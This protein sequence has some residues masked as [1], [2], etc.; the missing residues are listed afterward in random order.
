ML[1][2]LLQP[3]TRGNRHILNSTVTILFSAIYVLVI[4]T[5]ANGQTV[6]QKASPPGTPA[7]VEE[8]I[9]LAEV[10]S[11]IADLALQDD[12]LPYDQQP[13]YWLSVRLEKITPQLIAGLDDENPKIAERCL[14]LLRN[15]P[16]SK[17]LID[18]LIAKAN[19]D[20]RSLRYGVLFQLEK[21]VADPRVIHVLDQASRD[22]KNA[23]KPLHRARWA[24]LA[25]H[26]DRAMEIVKR[27]LADPKRDFCD[28]LDAVR[29]LGKI[30]DENSVK[31]LESVAADK[32]DN[33]AIE[34]YLTLAKIDPVKHGLT[35]DQQFLLEITRSGKTSESAFRER[36]SELG[37]LNVKE[38]RPLVMHMLRDKR[39]EALFILAAWKDQE[40]LPQIRKL[41][42]EENSPYQQQVCV[43]TYLSIDN[44]REAQ[45]TVL[46]FLVKKSDRSNEPILRGIGA[47]AMPADIK[48]SML[49]AAKPK[50]KSI[51]STILGALSIAKYEGYDIQDMLAPLMDE[52]TDLYNLGLYCEFAVADKEKRFAGQVRHAM[53]LLSSQPKKTPQTESDLSEYSAAGHLILKAVAA[54]ELKDLLADVKD[55][56]DSEDASIR[57]SALAAA[58]ILGDAGALEKLYARLNDKDLE[59]RKQASR[60]IQ[61]TK[62]IDDKARDVR[63]KTIIAC[64]GRPSEDYAMRLLTACG[65]DKAIEALKPILDDPNLQRSIH[66]AWVLAQLPDKK[67][68]DVAIRRLAIYGLFQWSH[69]QCGSDCDFDIAPEINFRQYYLLFG[70]IGKEGPVQIPPDLLVSL[71]LNDAEQEYAIRCY[72]A[73]NGRNSNPPHYIHF[74]D[75]WLI[76]KPTLDRSYLPLL[77]KIAAH[78]SRLEQL[79]VQGNT[80]S[81]YKYRQMA[82]KKISALTNEKATYIGIK[83]ETLDSEEFPKP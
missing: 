27:L 75:D 40:S 33:P 66:A 83:G 6:I 15:A 12:R 36:M 76:P 65:S 51:R 56:I 3:E 78:D 79:K 57:Q 4:I 60:A 24:W 14:V 34:A 17:E 47:A 45:E 18:A 5:Y 68:A 67:A 42:H 52:E 37:K 32:Y 39:M 59:S 30:G 20:N 35:K 8:K 73:S 61:A 53:K 77:R 9:D 19:D 23:S 49:R 82:A 28:V 69:T 21:F 63:E 80:V 55:F 2:L 72:Q 70:D 13:D 31:L 74:L 26:N 1:M 46:S 62:I 11:K 44:S 71:S 81:H 25:G 54:Y 58:A 64:L 41:F 38:V 10:R 16:A 50:L 7:T 48:L 29:L 22:P 43:A